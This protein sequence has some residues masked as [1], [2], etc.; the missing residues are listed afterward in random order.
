MYIS[1]IVLPRQPLS[2]ILNM[3]HPTLPNNPQ[4]MLPHHNIHRIVT[5]P[6]H[7]NRSQRP[8]RLRIHNIHNLAPSPKDQPIRTR[9]D[10]IVKVLQRA[11]E[12]TAI[13]KNRQFLPGRRGYREI[14]GPKIARPAEVSARG[15]DGAVRGACV[16]HVECFAVGG[17][18][19]AVGVALEGDEFFGA[20][21]C[22]VYEV[23]C[24]L[25]GGAVGVE[26]AAL[27]FWWWC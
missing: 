7:P 3:P 16:G 2:H 4:L 20:Q 15:F 24:G 22:A 8:P 21:G 17:E 13:S 14:P 10:P 26:V 23:D 27:F 9:P 18:G 6:S 19:D 12:Q 11:T 1:L 5:I 25:R